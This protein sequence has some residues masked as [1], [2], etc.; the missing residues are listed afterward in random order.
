M[1]V[2]HI[3]NGRRGRRGRAR[4]GVEQTTRVQKYYRKIP[5]PSDIPRRLIGVIRAFRGPT[6]PTPSRRPKP[7]AQQGA[8]IDRRILAHGRQGGGHVDADGDA[9][10]GAAYPGI[11]ET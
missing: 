3:G 4:I 5:Q 2:N 8:Q 6:K 9:L 1:V 10:H 7:P 11:E